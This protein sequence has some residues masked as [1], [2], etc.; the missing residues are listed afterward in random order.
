MWRLAA[1]TIG[2]E[3]IFCFFFRVA[4]VRDLPSWLKGTSSL[5]PECPA[6][7]LAITSS[8]VD[9]CQLRLVHDFTTSQKAEVITIM[10]VC[11]SIHLL[12]ED[13]CSR[14]LRVPT[15]ISPILTGGAES[16]L[17]S[18]CSWQVA[19]AGNLSCCYTLGDGFN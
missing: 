10:N 7:S 16:M 8:V 18:F 6:I 1:C 17:R 4:M 5:E 13:G 19:S 11:Y 15:P 14:C 2:I 12:T 3:L 9:D